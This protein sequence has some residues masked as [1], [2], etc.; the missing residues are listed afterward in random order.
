MA[1]LA[2]GRG[3]S[4]GE[5]TT[6]GPAACPPKLPLATPGSEGSEARHH[7]EGSGRT[8][9]VALTMEREVSGGLVGAEVA[10]EDAGVE[11]G[12]VD[13]HQRIERIAERRVGIERDQLRI[14]LEVLANEDRHALAVV[15]G[16]APPAD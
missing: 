5:T 7:D 14:Q 16:I 8:R 4:K 13:D 9:G 2:P 12:E 15:L 10:L 11:G 3:L 6:A 1:G